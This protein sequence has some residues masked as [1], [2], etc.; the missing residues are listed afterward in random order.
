MIVPDAAYISEIL[1]F[2]LGFQN[3]TIL[4][5]KMI[6]CLRLASEQLSPQYHYDFGMRA[7]RTVLSMA[8]VLKRREPNMAEDLLL[9]KTLRDCNVPKFVDQDIPVFM[10][11]L[12]D[13]F[14]GVE[15]MAP[16]YTLLSK[17]IQICLEDMNLQPI[18]SFLTKCLQLYDTLA[19]R[20]GVMLVGGTCSGKSTCYKV[21]AKAISR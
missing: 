15:V 19:S 8:G 17:S 2:S 13:L 6:N 7:I 9:L 4:S 20:H 16:D 10:G 21:L 11:I 14:P 12:T 1:L 3:A 18:P 5:R